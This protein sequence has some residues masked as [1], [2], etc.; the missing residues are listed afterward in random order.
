MSQCRYVGFALLLLVTGLA[1]AIGRGQ[2]PRQPNVV[3]ILADDQGWGDLSANQNPWVTTPHI[4]Q[5]AQQGARFEHFYVS[6]LCAPTRASL[7]T[8]RYHLATGVVSVSKGLETMNSDETTLG[9][10]FRANGY[11]TG[12]FGKWHSGQH[13]P[14]RPRDQGFD[15]F[16]GFCAGHWSNYFDTTLDRVPRKEAYEVA[17]WGRL[18]PAG[19]RH[20]PGAGRQSHHPPQS[21]ENTRRYGSRNQ[22]PAPAFCG[23]IVAFRL[24]SYPL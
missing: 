13:Y 4:D 22:G 16:L 10:L 5:L 12:L 2:P 19:R 23:N 9:E 20:V 21:P 8:G 18:G 11:Q 3:L 14:N 24:V 6:P 17:G 15:E 7:L 1:G